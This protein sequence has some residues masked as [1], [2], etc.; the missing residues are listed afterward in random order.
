MSGRAQDPVHGHI[1]LE[2]ET[3]EDGGKTKF[4]QKCTC[5]HCSKTREA[6][7]SGGG[8]VAAATPP[9][10]REMPRI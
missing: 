2:E 4:R 8:R 6:C 10:Y 1:L 3:Y 5:V 7:T 9:R